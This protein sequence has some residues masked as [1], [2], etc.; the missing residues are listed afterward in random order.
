MSWNVSCPL[1][2]LY[3]ILDCMQ[4]LFSKWQILLPRYIKWVNK[5]ISVVFRCGHSTHALLSAHANWM[6]RSSL[7]LGNLYGLN[8]R[9]EDQ[10]PFI[11]WP[12]LCGTAD[13]HRSLRVRP[14]K[15]R[16]M[17][18]KIFSPAYFSYT[19]DNLPD[20]PCT[21]SIYHC[22]WDQKNKRVAENKCHRMLS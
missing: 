21:K 14:E 8:E 18:Q 22:F 6:R 11:Q 2:W 10:V 7:S 9:T 3:E 4:Q 16:G 13:E 1:L 15:L 19:S 5:K 12:A 17:Q 20:L